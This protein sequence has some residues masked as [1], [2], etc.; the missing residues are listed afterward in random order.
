VAPPLT[1]T[2]A[3]AVDREHAPRFARLI[4]EQ[5]GFVWR[6]LRCIGVTEGE[7]DNAA[8]EVF[9]AVGRRIGDIRAGNERAFLFSTTLHV[10]ART[11]RNRDE[12]APPISDTALAL[13][14]LDE[15]QQAR[16]VLGAL[17]VQMAL[18]LRVV[19]VLSEI[20]R[21]ETAD[22]AEVVGIP[23]SVVVTRLRDAQEEFATHLDRDSDY[24]LALLA[25]AREERAP[26]E[27]V[28]RTLKA[29]GLDP[30]AASADM[31]TSGARR[32]RG[33]G[34]PRSAF[35]L[36]A[37]WLVLGWLAGLVLSSLGYALSDAA[38]GSPRH[39]AALR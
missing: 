36:A 28:A 14:D 39:G 6:L 26:A 8:R 29:A 15:Q 4:R 24:S 2:G 20:E 13:E 12:Q 22:I 7:A 37:K 38:S 23:E 11:R 27:V 21:L 18:E 16:E 17:L 33:P 25:A 35:T 30:A 5:F 9:A 34:A 19:F 10:A 32:T 31:S 3:R 1:E